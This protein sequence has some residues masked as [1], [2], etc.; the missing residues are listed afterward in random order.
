MWSIDSY[1]LELMA[2]AYDAVDVYNRIRL[3][4]RPPWRLD[5]D[6]LDW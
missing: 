2:G 5:P 3:D 1:E 4:Y 6:A